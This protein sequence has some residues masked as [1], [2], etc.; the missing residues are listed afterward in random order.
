MECMSKVG[1][2]GRIL[3]ENPYG[4]ISLERNRLRSD[5]VCY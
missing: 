4:K 5:Y 3:V 2:A 1:K